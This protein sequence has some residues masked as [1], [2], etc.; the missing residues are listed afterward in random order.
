MH[1][2]ESILKNEMHKLL[3]DFGI[4]TDHLISAR[5]P[6]QSNNQQEENLPN[7]GLCCKIEKNV[8]LERKLKV[9]EKKYKYNGPC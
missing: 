2:P 1:N 9:S 6:D 8:K 3:W 5:W 4:Q 7:C